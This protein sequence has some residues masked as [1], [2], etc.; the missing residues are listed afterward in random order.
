LHGGGYVIGSINTHRAMIAKLAGVEVEL[1]VWDD[2]IHVWHVFAKLLPEGQQAID[3]VGK[4]V[5]ARTS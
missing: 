1:E 5:I 2:M 3:K 4:F